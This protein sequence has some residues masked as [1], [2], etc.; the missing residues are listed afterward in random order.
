MAIQSPLPR[1]L[2]TARLLANITQEQLGK[3]L[4]FEG[5]S[6]SARMSQYEKGKHAPDFITAKRLANE[7]NIPVAYLYCDDDEMAEMILIFNKLISI[8]K[9]H[10]ISDMQKNFNKD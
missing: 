3:N 6:A 4:G 8:D 5:T 10:L 7:L 2:K 1:R 9:T